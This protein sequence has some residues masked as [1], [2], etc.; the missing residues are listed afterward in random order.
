MTRIAQE[1]GWRG[2]ASGKAVV[3]AARAGDVACLAALE[4]AA[5]HLGAA[6]ATLAMLLDLERIVLG[7]L[8]VHAAD[9]LLPRLTESLRARA[10]SRLTEGLEVVPAALGDRAQDLATLCAWG[11]H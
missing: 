1:C 4:Q 3:E 7:T 8:A 10:W 11:G 5:D 6:L 9:L 2:A